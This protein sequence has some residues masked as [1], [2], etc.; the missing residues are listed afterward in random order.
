MQ[1][2][3]DEDGKIVYVTM[4]SLEAYGLQEG[5]RRLKL[6]VYTWIWIY[7]LVCVVSIVGAFVTTVN[8][9][10]LSDPDFAFIPALF[11][12]T[13]GLSCVFAAFNVLRYRAAGE[14]KSYIEENHISDEVLS[15]CIY[16]KTKG[17]RGG[18]AVVD[19]QQLRN[20]DAMIPRQTAHPT[21]LKSLTDLNLLVTPNEEGG[22]HDHDH[23]Y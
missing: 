10:L 15:K 12:L 2:G 6:R 7:S 3:R 22:D 17:Q 5:V 16:S 9:Q 21:H 4:R 20:I 8:L 11:C 19:E 14:I 18:N 1:F 23:L 13:I